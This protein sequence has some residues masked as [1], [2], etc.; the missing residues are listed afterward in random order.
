MASDGSGARSPS[1]PDRRKLLIALG[2]AGAS[3]AALGK[4]GWS[5]FGPD[6]TSGAAA[7]RVGGRPGGGAQPVP[8]P[9][10]AGAAAQPIA[11]HVYDLAIA[12]GRVIDPESG[13]D[14][15][16]HVGVDAGSITAVS[17]TPLQAKR[18]IDATGKVVAPGFIDVLSYEPNDEGA[19]F[20]IGDGVTTNLG[21]HGMQNGDYAKPFFARYTGNCPVH[22]GGAFPDHWVRYHQCDLDVGD[23][24][25][26]DQVRALADTFEQELHNGWIG[27]D[28]EPEYTPGVD[29]AEMKALSEVAQRYN[30]PVFVHGRYSSFQQEHLTVPE[31]IE[32]AKQTGATV[33]V[34]H[35]P[36]TGGTWDIDQA[37]AEIHAAKDAGYHISACCYPYNYWATYLGSARF[38]DGWQD[39]YRISYGDL[40]IAG[41]DERVTASSFGRYQRSNKLAVAYA[42]PEDS[43]RKALRDP[44][45]MIGSDAILTSGNNHPRATGCFS[46]TL[47]PYARDAGVLS[48]TDALTKMTIQPAKLLEARA[49]ALARKG[50]VQ[51]GA[52]AD[53]CVFD[54][55]TVS[56][57][58]TVADPAQ[59]SAGIEWVLVAGQVAKTP[60]GVQTSVRAGQPITSQLQSA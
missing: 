46:R 19:F 13:F 31:I 57:R 43:V 28:F 36:S 8:P 30:A 11:E 15:M 6:S 53:I 9:A 40:Q 17:L 50:R 5:V 55:A 32:I 3:V 37:L 25:S 34:S 35:L 44:L 27:I 54:P 18:S 60:A 42:I 7:H 21:M 48:L 39:R 29:F 33:H 51:R 16:A 20:K 4:L 56:D 45:V 47:G 59:Y 14:R 22:F 38:S 1:S 49:P 2:Y 26:A 41:T 58:S 23:T 12:G 24:A 10:I 52:D